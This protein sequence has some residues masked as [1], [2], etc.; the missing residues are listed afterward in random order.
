VPIYGIMT[1]MELNNAHD[2]R[3]SPANEAELRVQR[4]HR[5]DLRPAF[6]DYV[7]RATARW[8]LAAWPTP[9]PLTALHRRQL[10]AGAIGLSLSDPRVRA[11]CLLSLDED[12][13]NLSLLVSAIL[14][15]AQARGLDVLLGLAQADASPEQTEAAPTYTP[16]GGAP[17]GA[18]RTPRQQRACLMSRSS[19]GGSEGGHVAA[20]VS[21]H[22]SACTTA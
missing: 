18:E 21:A 3:W 7:Y 4:A 10:A 13:E 15:S 17:P 20:P 5:K 19:A 6:P 11:L 12:E 16:R 9:D 8:L 14:A 22:H 1:C 2:F